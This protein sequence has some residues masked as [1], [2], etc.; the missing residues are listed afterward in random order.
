MMQPQHLPLHTHTP[1]IH[2]HTHTHTLSLSLSLPL[3][4]FSFCLFL[5]HSPY[6]SYISLAASLFAQYDISKFANNGDDAF[7]MDKTQFAHFFTVRNFSLL[8]LPSCPLLFPLLI[9]SPFFACSFSLGP[10]RA[11]RDRTDYG[12]IRL[13]CVNHYTLLLL[14]FCLFSSFPSSPPHLYMFT[15]PI[16]VARTLSSILHPFFFQG[17]PCPLVVLEVLP[18]M[19]PV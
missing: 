5:P 3:F 7:K 9:V 4:L 1:H 10:L 13:A 12:A 14:R 6:L 11:A 8:L 15:E 16:P 2:A 19:R 17:C 18:G